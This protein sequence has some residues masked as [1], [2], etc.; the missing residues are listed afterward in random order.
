MSKV[1]K[2]QKHL[3]TVWFNLQSSKKGQNWSNLLGNA[4]ICGINVKKKQEE[5]YHKNQNKDFL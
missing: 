3:Y 5:Q 2:A 1:S 4:Y